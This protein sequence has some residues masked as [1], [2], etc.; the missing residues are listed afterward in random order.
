MAACSGVLWRW[1]LVL[2]VAFRSEAI[3]VNRN[4]V[5]DDAAPPKEKPCPDGTISSFMRGYNKYRATGEKPTE[6][7][8]QDGAP[9][10]CRSLD[11]PSGRFAVEEEG[12]GGKTDKIGPDT[13]VEVITRDV[14]LAHKAIDEPQLLAGELAA[15]L[16]VPADR[17]EVTIELPV[18]ETALKKELQNLTDELSQAAFLSQPMFDARASTPARG[19]FVTKRSAPAPSTGFAP[20]PALQ[21]APAPAH[22]PTPA[23]APVVVEKTIRFEFIVQNLDYSTLE[24]AQGPILKD[25]RSAVL[26]AITSDLGVN[27]DFVV[28]RFLSGSLIIQVELLEDTSPLSNSPMQT[29]WRL[30]TNSTLTEVVT[31]AINSVEGVDVF[32][33][34]PVSVSDISVKVPSFVKP[35]RVQFLTVDPCLVARLRYDGNL[36]MKE[37]AKTLD[38]QPQQLVLEPP[39]MDGDESRPWLKGLSLLQQTRFACDLNPEAIALLS[40]KRQSQRS[41][42]GSSG[43]AADVETSLSPAPAPVAGYAASPASAPEPPPESALS[44]SATAAG[45]SAAAAPRSPSAA[46]PAPAPT[47]VEVVNVKF[48]IANLDYTALI[49][50]PNIHEEMSDLIRAVVATDAGSSVSAK[51]VQVSFFPGSVKVEASIIPSAGANVA[52]IKNRLATSAFLSAS[53]L[54]GVQAVTGLAFVS[55]GPVILLGPVSVTMGLLGPRQLFGS[56]APAPAASAPAPAPAPAPASRAAPEANS[57]RIAVWSITVLPPL[58]YFLADRLRDMVNTPHGNLSRLLPLTLARVP[59]LRY[60]S[61]A[62][63][64]SLP[65]IPL[66]LPLNNSIGIGPVPGG[67]RDNDLMKAVDGVAAVA[68]AQLREGMAVHVAIAE[69]EWKVLKAFDLQENFLADPDVRG[70]EV[71]PPFVAMNGPGSASPYGPWAPG[72]AVADPGVPDLPPS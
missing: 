9:P 30:V 64:A 37:I 27:A 21:P 44:A 61:Y 72:E 35:T 32:A 22:V 38:V 69:A 19:S 34:G 50:N 28:L 47:G 20:G 12:G 62:E 60:P 3:V 51:E 5:L 67:H 40:R 8:A 15:A 41:S 68:R 65:V 49:A 63:N 17:L 39:A 16:G 24:A 11:G 2:A 54:A 33:S 23:P 7:P 66:P 43:R 14:P 71:A 42:S 56:S 31:L 45:P 10:C 70:V 29:L 6:P 13:F 4:A 53:L 58:E 52:K 18:N 25:I 57:P 46:A 26:H 55:V 48:T 59:G 36:Y 1:V